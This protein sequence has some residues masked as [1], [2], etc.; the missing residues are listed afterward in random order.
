LVKI[1]TP[2]HELLRPLSADAHGVVFIRE[3]FLLLFFFLAFLS[4]NKK[5]KNKKRNI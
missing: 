2:P 3:W 1:D 4:C 5:N